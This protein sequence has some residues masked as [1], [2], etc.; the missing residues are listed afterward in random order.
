MYTFYESM[1]GLFS[2]RGDREA[3][4]SVDAVGDTTVGAGSVAH[5]GITA[6]GT[7]RVDGSVE[8]DVEATGNVIIG[9]EG[10]V[11]GMIK[12][13]SVLVA[14]QVRGNITTANRLEIVSTGK[15]WGDVTAPTLLIEEGALF[16]GRSLMHGPED[17]PPEDNAQSNA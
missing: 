8:G 2:R 14:G 11:Q 9:K 3:P 16:S 10:R 13:H 15:V 1:A 4:I 12:G 17:T 7:V 5:G 6:Q